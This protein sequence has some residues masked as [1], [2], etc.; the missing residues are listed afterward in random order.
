VGR[1]CACCTLIPLKPKAAPIPWFPLGSI[2]R[3]QRGQNLPSA[4]P[5][6]SLSGGRRVNKNSSQSQVNASMQRSSDQLVSLGGG[7]RHQ[8]PPRLRIVSSK[9]DG[10]YVFKIVAFNRLA[11]RPG[12]PFSDFRAPQNSPRICN[13]HAWKYPVVDSSQ[14]LWLLGRSS[15]S[16]TTRPLPT[17]GIPWFRFQCCL[18]RKDCSFQFSA[19]EKSHRCNVTPF[20]G[21]EP[22]TFSR[23][24][25]PMLGFRLLRERLE[26][27]ATISS[28]E[29]CA[30][31]LA[32]DA[33]AARDV[34]EDF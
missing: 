30:A 13:G 11:V 21:V 5:R 24:I 26:V 1:L 32:K 16:L 20:V 27:P 10:Y 17:T 8:G 4:I 14:L 9:R 33:F 25:L 2:C 22:D 34:I 28:R 19:A 29:P 23:L 6:R 12:N 15:I 18:M 7:N 3:S 31:N